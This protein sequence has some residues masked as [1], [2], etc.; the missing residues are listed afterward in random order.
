MMR[1]DMKAITARGGAMRTSVPGE[2]RTMV[3][4]PV[5]V[6]RDTRDRSYWEYLGE[7]IRGCGYSGRQLVCL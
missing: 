1:R 6:A 3:G 5:S 7:K 4:P 2:R